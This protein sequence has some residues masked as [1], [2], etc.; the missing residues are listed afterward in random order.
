M[1]NSSAIL[2]SCSGS[3]KV[4][5][6]LEGQI[7]KWSYIEFGRANLLLHLCMDF[8]IMWHSCSF[9]TIVPVD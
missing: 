5:V 4:N 1:R 3:L 9:E 7:I 2:S 8:K 6:T